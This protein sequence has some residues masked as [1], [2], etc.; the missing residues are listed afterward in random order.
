MSRQNYIIHKKRSFAR[1]IEDGRNLIEISA[2]ID[3]DRAASDILPFNKLHLRPLGEL[4]VLYFEAFQA[5][6]QEGFFFVA[7]E[8][9][10][11]KIVVSS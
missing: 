6:V 10:S 7:S 8:Q 1:I 5:V 3:M 2:D 4:V 11:P 9:N